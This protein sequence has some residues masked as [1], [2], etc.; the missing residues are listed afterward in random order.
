MSKKGVIEGTVRESSYSSRRGRPVRPPPRAR[1]CRHIR[2]N[3]HAGPGR[4]RTDR[5]R[6]GHPASDGGVGL[7]S[8][9]E[10]GPAAGRRCT[11]GRAAADSAHPPAPRIPHRT[12]HR[13]APRTEPR[14]P[15]S[16]APPTARRPGSPWPLLRHMDRHGCIGPARSANHRTLA[17]QRAVAG[18]PTDTATTSSRPRPAPPGPPRH[19]LPRG[20]PPPRPRWTPAEGPAPA[21]LPMPDRQSGRLAMTTTLGPL[22]SSAGSRSSATGRRPACS[23]RS[24]SCSG[25]HL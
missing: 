16:G 18:S 24:T 9:A 25:R 2:R 15:A 21:P 19:P 17:P 20:G 13:T 5:V 6:A 10:A 4:P 3:A 1:G 8:A 7:Q 22:Y 14:C 23:I 11:P 12:W